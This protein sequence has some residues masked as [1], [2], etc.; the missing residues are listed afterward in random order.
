MNKLPD[1]GGATRADNL[2]KPFPIQKFKSSQHNKKSAI[3]R[4]GSLWNLLPVIVRNLPTV[5]DFKKYMKQLQIN[6]LR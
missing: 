5:N 2:D 4:G 3:F 6:K 1:R